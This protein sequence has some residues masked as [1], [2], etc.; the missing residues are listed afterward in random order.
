MVYILSAGKPISGFY[1]GIIP[2]R[3]DDFTKAKKYQ[4]RKAQEIVD[5]MTDVI[6]FQCP[7]RLLTKYLPLEMK[8]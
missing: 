5:M 4:K 2:A 1:H 7:K 8:E 3:Q 6:K